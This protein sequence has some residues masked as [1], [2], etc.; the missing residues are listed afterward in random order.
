ME[1]NVS[2]LKKTTAS[3]I[4]GLV[5]A[6]KKQL[7]S[8]G[9]IASGNLA[10]NISWDITLD[11]TD[12]KV[13]FDLPEYW[14]YVEYG[15]KPGKFPPLDKIKSWIRVKPV[16]PRA[17]ANGK[18][19]SENQLAFLIGRKIATKGTKGSHSLAKAVTSFNAQQKIVDAIAK[20]IV[21]SIK[22]CD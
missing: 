22:F 16:L 19:P 18:I 5:S 15:R 12:L 17:N 4:S 11:G 1:L 14:K 21:D 2:D 10:N 7:E 13:I 20:S 9:K 3:V 6:Y 8:D